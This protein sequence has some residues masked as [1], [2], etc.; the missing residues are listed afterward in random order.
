MVSDWPS[1]CERQGKPEQGITQKEGKAERITEEL[2]ECQGVARKVVEQGLCYES[3]NPDT[4]KLGESRSK[5]GFVEI[6]KVGRK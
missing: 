6:W 3:Q 4:L 2:E 1:T 5:V